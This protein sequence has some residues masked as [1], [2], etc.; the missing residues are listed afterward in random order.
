MSGSKKYSVSLP[1]ELAEAV[2]ARV[3]PG[4]FSAYVAAALEHKV[5]MD[6]LGELVDDYVQHHGPLS[7]EDLEAARKEFEQL[8]SGAPGAAA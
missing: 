5:A 3:E 4:G 6:K 7:A 1:E 2:R 8:E